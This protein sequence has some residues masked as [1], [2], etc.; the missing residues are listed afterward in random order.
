MAKRLTDGK[1]IAYTDYRFTFRVPTARQEAHQDGEPFD[2]R[3]RVVTDG[4]GYSSS[5]RT[6]QLPPTYCETDGTGL[7]KLADRGGYR[8][9]IE[10][11]DVP[12][13]HG[14]ARHAGLVVDGTSVYFTAKVGKNVELFE[15]T[16]DG[17]PRSSPRPP[18]ARCTTTRNRRRTGRGL[19]TGRFEREFAT[20]MF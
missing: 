13:F 20:S 6:L 10:F 2:L 7:K 1:L 3:S 9:V 11:L 16:L 19:C 4:S 17:R 14:A 8:G 18:T 5:A 15:T 12:D